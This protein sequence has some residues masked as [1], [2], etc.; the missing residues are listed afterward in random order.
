MGTD[1][2]TALNYAVSRKLGI[3]I[4]NWQAI[5][6]SILFFI[7]LFSDRKYIGLGTLANMFLVGYSL[8]FF[9]ALW[10]K[11]LPADLFTKL[12]VR[13]GILVPSLLVFV[14]AAAVYMDMNLGTGPYDAV[15]FILAKKFPKVS[16]KAVRIFYDSSVIVIAFALDG[17]IGI[18]TV[19][20]AF[21]LG[22]AVE[23]VGRLIA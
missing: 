7:V 12:P 16:L 23:W 5:L 2:Y 11:V 1:P 21:T 15:A 14:L 22:P 19:L 9:L 18:L 13:I 6:N 8:D 20:I 17:S 4:G 3:S 10:N